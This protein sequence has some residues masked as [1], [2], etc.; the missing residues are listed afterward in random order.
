MDGFNGLSSRASIELVSGG[1]PM[2]HSVLIG[3]T[4]IQTTRWPFSMPF[5]LID[6]VWKTFGLK[7]D[8]RVLFV[9]DPRFPFE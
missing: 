7:A 2:H 5:R 6:G 4:R 1:K 8:G 3:F 9:G